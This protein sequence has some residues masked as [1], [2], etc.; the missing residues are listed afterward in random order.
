M[1]QDAAGCGKVSR[2]LVDV[3]IQDL[4]LRLRHGDFLYFGSLLEDAIGVL[5]LP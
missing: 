2:I 3:E 4:A 5:R 1:S